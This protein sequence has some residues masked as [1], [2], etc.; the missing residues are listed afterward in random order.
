[1]NNINGINSYQGPDI[2]R[3]EQA[4]DL[5]LARISSPTASKTDQVEISQ[6]ARLMSKLSVV[7]DVRADKVNAIRQ[8]LADGSYDVESK[9]PQA[10]DKMLDEY[11]GNP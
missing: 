9:L 10:L 8:G 4:K 7:P 2:V 5:N 6:M 1:M 3:P 11:L